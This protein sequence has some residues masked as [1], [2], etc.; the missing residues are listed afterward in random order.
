MVVVSTL[1]FAAAFAAALGAIFATVTP[2]WSLIIALLRHGPTADWAPLPP[3]RRV[4][5]R[6]SATR[7]AAMSVRSSL[8][9]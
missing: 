1:L 9:A 8:A 5:R 2:R 7:P 6:A 3:Q 4:A